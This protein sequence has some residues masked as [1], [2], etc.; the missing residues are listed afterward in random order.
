MPILTVIFNKYANFNFNIFGRKNRKQRPVNYFK[1]RCYL[2]G[3]IS[4][5][6]HL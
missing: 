5:L 2:I 3:S 6:E 4:K 1:Y